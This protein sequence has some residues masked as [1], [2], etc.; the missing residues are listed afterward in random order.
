[1]A[2]PKERGRATDPAAPTGCSRGTAVDRDEG[3]VAIKKVGCLPLALFSEM[4]SSIRN[5]RH[6]GEQDER[7][8][9]S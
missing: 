3:I 1:M 4:P 6:F 8:K 9:R 5:T 7:E 2:A